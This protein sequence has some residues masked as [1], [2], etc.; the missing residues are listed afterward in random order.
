MKILKR[1]QVW[2]CD[3]H[4]LTWKWIWKWTTYYWSLKPQIFWINSLLLKLG[5]CSLKTLRVDNKFWSILR[6]STTTGLATKVLWAW[7]SSSLSVF[8]RISKFVPEVSWCGSSAIPENLLSFPQ[9][10]NKSGCTAKRRCFLN[11]F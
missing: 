9:K 4:T 11:L 3:E 7:F 2:Q 8:Q 6:P 5:I 1:P 10:S